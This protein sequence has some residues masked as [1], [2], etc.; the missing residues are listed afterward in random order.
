MVWPGRGIGWKQF[1]KELKQ[2]WTD[3]KVGDVAAALT[4][5]GILAIFPFLLFLVSLAGLILDPQLAQSLTM[6]LSAV[7]PPA[8]TTILGNQLQSLAQSGSAGLL[9]VSGVG[10][11]WAASGGV[12]A[13]IRSLNR[14]YGVQESRPFWKVRGLAIVG[15]L[16]GAAIGLVA[17]LVAVFAPVVADAIGGPVPTLASWARLPVAGLL[18]MFVWA[19]AYWALPDVEQRFRFITPGSVIG[20]VIW[21]AASW[22]FSVYVQNFG[23]Y[24]ATYGALAGVIVLLF[25]M[26]ITSQVILLGAEINALLEH[27]SPEGKRTGAKRMAEAGPDRPKAAKREEEDRRRMPAP[28]AVGPAAPD[29]PIEERARAGFPAPN[30]GATQ[31]DRAGPP[32]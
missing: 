8:A 7:A 27:R 9:T 5:F 2:E 26:W 20:V 17:A 25:W 10:A 18:M 31:D 6:E 3:D 32:P 4:F 24:E 16:V 13:L 29:R 1:F 12:R 14:V 19:L 28:S 21:I 23:N 11:I 22:G 30:P 15:T